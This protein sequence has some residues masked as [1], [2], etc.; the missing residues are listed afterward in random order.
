MTNKNY[1]RG[2]SFEY[3]IINLLK[4]HLPKN[5]YT[6]IRTAGSHSPI[7]II[8]VKHIKYGK[9]KSFGIQC[10]T[11]KIKNKVK[12]KDVNK[13]KDEEVGVFD[14]GQPHTPLFSPT[15]SI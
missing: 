11:K 4:H 10:K 8:I 1:I 3:E 2:R 15:S 13:H 12:V 7:D 6:I 14:I 9:N 5:K